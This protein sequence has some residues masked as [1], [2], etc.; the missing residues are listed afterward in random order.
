MLKSQT[1]GKTAPSTGRGYCADPHSVHLL[2]NQLSHHNVVAYLRAESDVHIIE[3]Q[4]VLRQFCQ[5][6]GYKI[7]GEFVDRSTRPELGLDNAVKAL[8]NADAIIVSDLERLVTHHEMRWRDLRPLLHQFACEH[9]KHLISVAEGINT[10][11]PGGQRSLIEII[12]Q[13]KDADESPFLLNDD[14]GK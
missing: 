14:G 9:G 12:T 11:S 2:G 10:G 8:G 3:Q 1:P 5:K 13:H 4:Q 6:N 7:V